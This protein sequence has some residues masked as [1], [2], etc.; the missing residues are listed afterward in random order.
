M[1][2]TIHLYWVIPILL[3]L[4]L[5]MVKSWLVIGLSA[6]AQ[7]AYNNEEYSDAAG[8]YRAIDVLPVGERWV[9]WF[10]NGTALAKAENYEQASASL[11]TALEYVPVANAKAMEASV[12]RKLPMCLVRNN[13][14]YSI[15]GQGDDAQVKGD[16][17]VERMQREQVALDALAGAIP[18][19]SKDLPDPDKYRLQ[20]ISA[21]REAEDFYAKANRVRS[22]QGCPDDNATQ[23]TVS[24][25]A[26][27]AKAKREALEQESDEQPEDQQDQQ[28][29]ETDPSD[30]PSTDPSAQP[31]T[32]PS[33]DP[34]AEPSASPSTD[35]SSQPSTDPSD[36]PSSSPSAQPSTDPDE[37][38]ELEQKQQELEERNKA[39]QDSRQDYQDY[40]S[41][42]WNYAP[43]GAKPW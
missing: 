43:P 38:S 2:R 32:D 40:N 20:A 12:A 21:Y 27:E 41:P 14:A 6:R 10:N 8:L 36:E 1:K 15:A 4:L 11:N 9:V 22:G 42:S 39:G 7:S 23:T 16:N 29:P 26:A 19:D 31:S 18:E 24:Q 37:L 28:D 34:S 5:V 30:E 13:L 33:G 35:P 3:A 25:A 17:L